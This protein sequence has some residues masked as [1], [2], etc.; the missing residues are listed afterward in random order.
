MSCTLCGK[1]AISRGL[2]GACYQRERKAGRLQAHGL[3]Q[4]AACAADGCTAL[5]DY[6]GL[7]KRHAERARRG[8]LHKRLIESLPGERWVAIA[9]RPGWSV[10]TEGRIKSHRRSGHEHLLS[11]TMVDGRM[12]VRCGR[13]GYIIVHLAVLR[14]FRPGAEGRAVFL[15]RDPANCRLANLRWETLADR[16]LAALAMAEQSTSR[17]RG[18]FIGFWSGDNAALDGF[19][20]EMRRLLIVVVPRKIASYSLVYQADADDVICANLARVFI[21]VNSAT[22]TSL[23]NLP[24]YVLT[25]ADRYL[26]GHWRYAR[27]LQSLSVSASDG[28]VNVL[29]MVGWCSPSA[30]LEAMA[31]EAYPGICR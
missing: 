23:D 2:C 15:D 17:W 28:E 30:E 10:S 1:P 11:Q 16:R 26:A 7:C 5:A 27:G 29:D 9:G 25:V 14:A 12:R 22:L 31:R 13:D 4:R 6:H 20:E 24:A 18:A 3:H 8:T 21:S 19:I